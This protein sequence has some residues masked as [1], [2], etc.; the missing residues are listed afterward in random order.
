ML[1]ERYKNEIVSK[2]KEDLALGNVMQVPKLEKIVL[3]MGLGSAT[4]NPRIVEEAVD[5][6]TAITG[7]KAVTTRAK[8]AISNFKLRENIA[9]GAKV[10][11]HGDKMWEF[12]DRFINVSLPRTR[13]FRGI[14]KKGFDGR[15][16]YTMGVKEQTIFTEIDYDKVNNTLGMDISFVTSAE[17][18]DQGRALL[19]ELGLPFRK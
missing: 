4:K 11:L 14:S 8:K 6:L 18:D 2:L 10:T 15:G 16:N 13:D 9:I 17:N 19:T 7:Q 12:L 3:N 1:K 5:T